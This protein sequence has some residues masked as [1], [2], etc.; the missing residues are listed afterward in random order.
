[1]EGA[2]SKRIRPIKND[3]VDLIA[4]L[5]AGIDF[6]EDDVE[7]PQNDNVAAR[8][9]TVREELER[10][11]ETFGYGGM[12]TRGLR[13]II[14]GRPN[15]GKSSLFNRFVCSER[16]IVTNTPGTTRDVVSETIDLAGIPTR[17]SDTAGIRETQDVVESIGVGKTLEALVEMDMALVVIDGSAGFVY[18]DQRILERVYELPHIVVVNKSDLE[19]VASG[20]MPAGVQAVR[21]SAKTGAGLR[22]LQDAI[23]E[24]IQHR[25]TDALNDSILTNSRQNDAVLRAIEKLN[26]GVH[27]LSESVP[28]E[29]VLLDCYDAL[30]AL[31]ELTGEVVSDDILT[32]IFSTFCIGK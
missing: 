29:M 9:G 32:K 2:L 8:L 31:D 25:R 17:I 7:V 11:Q 24:F 1:M 4:R 13:L 19:P 3:L 23:R 16:A 5:E 6:A 12:L 15:V 10:L 26:K 28:H 20:S 30:S 27:A 14:L 22:Q 21:V 18:E